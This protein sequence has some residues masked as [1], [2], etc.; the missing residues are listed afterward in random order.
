MEHVQPL[1]RGFSW[2]GVALL[3]ALLL[4]IGL[5]TLGAV[6]LVQGLERTGQ[7]SGTA[8][9]PTK[10]APAPASKVPAA[11]LRARSHVSVLVLN[12][13]GATGAAGDEAARLLA[14]GYRRASAADATTGYATSLVLFRPGWAGE[15]RRLA[16]DAGIRTVA[17][18][19]G[20]LPSTDAGYRLVVILGTS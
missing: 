18:L 2:R 1:E 19:D 3:A 14:K 17:P 4:V 7:R 10:T 15:A 12:G 8:P 5:S 13:N 20:S 16:R 11:P 6:V 9:A